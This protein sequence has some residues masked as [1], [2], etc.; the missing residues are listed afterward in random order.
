MAA[1][2]EKKAQ[3]A[4]EAAKRKERLAAKKGL[5]QGEGPQ[6]P[7]SPSDLSTEENSTGLEAALAQVSPVA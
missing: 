1:K 6:S 2:L 7:K 5:V 3:K 4:Q